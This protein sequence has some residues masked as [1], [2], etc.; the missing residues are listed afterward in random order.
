MT[1]WK[2]DS[3]TDIQDQKEDS[4]FLEMLNGNLKSRPPKDLVPRQNEE[5]SVS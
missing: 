2:D 5:S 3:S 4:C 1:N